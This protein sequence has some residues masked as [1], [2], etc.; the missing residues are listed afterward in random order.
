MKHS[1]VVALAVFLTGFAN[2]GN[3]TPFGMSEI[4][5]N[6]DL[7][8]GAKNH[9]A[10]VSEAA[11]HHGGG[12]SAQSYVASVNSQSTLLSSQTISSSVSV[13]EP[14]TWLLLGGALLGLAPWR[15]Y[16]RDDHP[17]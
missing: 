5:Q 9:G 13:P 17:V 14:S 16:S 1:A 12:A 3:A 7:D 8:E 10:V 15:R 6:H 11:R 2:I 4:A